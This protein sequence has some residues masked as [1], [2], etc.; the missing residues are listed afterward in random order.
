MKIAIVAGPNFPVPPPDYGG[1]QRGVDDLSGWL[2]RNGHEVSV[3]ASADSTISPE[4]ATLIPTHDISL[5]NDP[6]LHDVDRHKAAFDEWKETVVLQLTTLCIENCPDIIN[7]RCEEPDIL[8]KV[9]EFHPAVVQGVSSPLAASAM[10]ELIQPGVVPTAHTQAHKRAMGNFDEIQVVPYGIDTSNAPEVT[11][12][13]SQSDKEPTLPILAQLKASGQDYLLHL[14]TIGKH[15]GQKTSIEVAKRA[16]IPIIIA[17]EPNNI[18]G[19]SQ[20]YFFNEIEPQFNGSNV[21]YFGKANEREKYEL[22]SFAKAT[23]FGTGFEDSAIQEPFGRVIAE[24]LICGT[25]VI[26]CRL[27]S[28]PELV[29]EGVAGFGFDT[30]EE[31]VDAI[32]RLDEISPYDCADHAKAELSIQKFGSSSEALFEELVQK[33][34]N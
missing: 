24:S 33:S 29:P 19:A 4:K 7:L 31:A 11:L 9:R 18:P 5:T 25:P 1:S 22:M 34:K 12:P 13:L 30:V 32:K 21:L 20:D 28:F 17:G 16:G 6:S 10:K 27:G 2:T 3:L 8:E 26:G 14:A 15:K 23:M